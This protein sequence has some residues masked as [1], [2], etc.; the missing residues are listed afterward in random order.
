MSAK[1]RRILKRDSG[2]TGEEPIYCRLDRRGLSGRWGTRVEVAEHTMRRANGAG[3]GV[4]TGKGAGAG[5]PSVSVSAPLSEG[6]GGYESRENSL[7]RAGSDWYHRGT[8]ETH[9]HH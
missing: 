1:I 9:L 5:G 4:V 7:K 2:R 8:I 3:V 6:S